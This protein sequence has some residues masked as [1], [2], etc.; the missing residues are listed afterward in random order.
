ML[1]VMQ[2]VRPCPLRPSSELLLVRGFLGVEQAMACLEGRGC[3][4]TLGNWFFVL[5]PSAANEGEN[6]TVTPPPPLHNMH[7]NNWK[8]L[9]SK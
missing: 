2:T 6:G 1:G 3:I 5:H 8:K 7:L 4:Q 9:E